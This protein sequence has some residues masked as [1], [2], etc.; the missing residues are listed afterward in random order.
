LAIPF[1]LAALGV[2]RA[3]ELMRR[4]ARAVQI[5]SRV[6]GVVMVIVGVLLFTGTLEQLA[7]FGFFVNL[8]L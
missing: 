3:A 7:R 6:T 5:V 2:G 8:G 1:L 4:H